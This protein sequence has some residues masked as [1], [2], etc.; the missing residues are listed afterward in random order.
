MTTSLSSIIIGF[1]LTKTGFDYLNR[2][3]VDNGFSNWSELANLGNDGI[4]QY[5]SGGIATVQRAFQGINFLYNLFPLILLIII[6]VVLSFFNLEK[7]LRKMRVEN[8]LN[9]DGSMIVEVN[10]SHN[11]LHE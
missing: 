10:S 2:A 9:E 8:G 11:D 1:V 5:V 4:N 6:V 3:V 7:D